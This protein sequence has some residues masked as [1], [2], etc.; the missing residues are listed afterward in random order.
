MKLHF[1]IN[2]SAGNGRGKKIWLQFEQ[3]LTIPYE[4][5]WT[6]YAGHTVEIAQQIAGQ[7][8]EKIQHV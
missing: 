1:I 6:E 4:V 7:A 5:H 3:Q 8:T 2:P